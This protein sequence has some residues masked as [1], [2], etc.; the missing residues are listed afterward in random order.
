MQ[1]IKIPELAESI[2]EGTIA[3]W[4]VKEGDKVEK[5]DAI[6][7]LETDKVNVEVNSEFSGVIAEITSNEG[8]DVSVGD[9]IGKLDENGEA[10]ASS[11]KEESKTEEADKNEEAPKEAPK[12]EPKQEAAPE[13]SNGD[14]IASPAA[15]KRARELG[16]DLSEVQTRDP[17][18][19]VRPDDVNA[20]NNA[21][22]KE[23][24]P[25]KPAKKEEP[26]S[27]KTEFDK[28]VERVKMTRRRQTIAKNLVEVQHNTAM[29]TTF[30]EVDMTSVM[31]LRKQRKDK[32]LEK[33]GVK[34]GFMS[35]F[36]K[37]VVG[38]LKEFPL[39]NAEIQGNE[40]VIKKFYDIGI[41]VSTDDG[42]VVPVVR[43]AD[44]K[45]FAGIEQDIVDLGTKARDN[46]LSLNDLQ[47]GSFTITNGGTFGS[48]MSTPILNAPQVGILGMHNIIKR[49]IAM[50][51]DSIEVR[52][53]M[54]I[55]LSYDHRIVDGKEAVQFLVRIKEML[56]DPYDLLLEG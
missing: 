22:K 41:A 52:P 36:A 26:K 24:A 11:G 20:H 51:D 37:A 42:L 2:T 55:A 27:E 49:P 30:N 10:G 8:E 53:M 47:G 40:L 3:E 9:I 39:L 25:S 35:F 45:D 5:G 6:V 17:L 46:K 34:L 12:E 32:F 16:I 1:E 50:P 48:M 54:Y 43:D 29:L 19:R 23:S 18:G 56:E 28:P 21:P 38:A 4:L 15:R 7:E 31:E 44:R 33:N 13:Q 14:V